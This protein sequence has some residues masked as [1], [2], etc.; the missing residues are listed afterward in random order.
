MKWTSAETGDKLVTGI[1]ILNLAFPLTV[2]IKE[3]L[4]SYYCVVNMSFLA[5]YE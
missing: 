3:N 2:F 5:F 1:L 4:H